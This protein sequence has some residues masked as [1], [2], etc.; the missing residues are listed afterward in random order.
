M[1]KFICNLKKYRQLKELTQEQLA[2]KVGVRRETIMR[3]E[4]GKYNP[5]LKLAIDISKIVDT[6]IDEL[7]IF[8]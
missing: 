2:E 1:P 4:A 8:D 3:L 5:S 6:P 7:F